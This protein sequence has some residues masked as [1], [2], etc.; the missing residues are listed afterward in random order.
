[1]MSVLKG[2]SQGSDKTPA[3]TTLRRRRRI[4]HKVKGKNPATGAVHPTACVASRSS[5]GASYEVFWLRFFYV[6]PPPFD[7]VVNYDAKQGEGRGRAGVLALLLPM[8]SW[9]K[10]SSSRFNI[11]VPSLASLREDGP[12]L[13]ARVNNN[14]LLRRRQWRGR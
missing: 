11:L 1:M 8:A 3:S 10:R 7:E 9:Q 2:E 4:P 6:L 13:A 5:S 14:Q 12:P